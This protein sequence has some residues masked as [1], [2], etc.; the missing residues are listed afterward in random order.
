M[1]GFI[2]LSSRRRDWFNSNLGIQKIGTRPLNG[3]PVFVRPE[4]VGY[5]ESSVSVSTYLGSTFGPT[6]PVMYL[7]A[8]DVVYVMGCEGNI[9]STTGSTAATTFTGQGPFGA[10]WNPFIQNNRTFSTTSASHREVAMLNARQNQWSPSSFVSTDWASVATGQ[11]AVLGTYRSFL[12]LRIIQVTETGMYTINTATGPR[13]TGSSARHVYCIAFRG[14]DTNKLSTV[15]YQPGG[16]DTQFVK[17]PRSRIA[18][19]QFTVGYYPYDPFIDVFYDFNI[20]GH[21]L[22]RTSSVGTDRKI[23]IGM[24]P[25]LDL[26]HDVT[27]LVKR[28]SDYT[29]WIGS[30]WSDQYDG[31]AGLSSMCGADMLGTQYASLAQTFNHS[32]V[33]ALTPSNVI[34]TCYE[35]IVPSL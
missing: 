29:E 28:R 20:Y 9:G 6:S 11:T 14:V 12:A 32:G 7:K 31:S 2:G 33:F 21:P 4:V 24:I 27:D 19:G 16:G 5:Y 17:S 8:G 10:T 18:T 22:I 15:Y 25:E 3:K 23:Q 35:I 34:S 13:G 1:D 30:L 26:C